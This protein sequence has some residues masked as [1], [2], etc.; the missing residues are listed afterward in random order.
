MLIKSKSR[1]TYSTSTPQIIMSNY[2]PTVTQD[3]ELTMANPEVPPPAAR[4]P[5]PLKSAP[6]QLD[7][8]GNILPSPKTK[9][10]RVQAHTRRGGSRVAA[11]VRTIKSNKVS[12]V[13][14]SKPKYDFSSMDPE[15]V[16]LVKSMMIQ[17]KLD[18]VR[19]NK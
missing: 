10:V 9:S 19:G 16:K 5:R 13:S 7:L 17:E 8:F 15:T 14:K 6:K 4:A 12:K 2:I 18:M 11:H 1:Q 3:E